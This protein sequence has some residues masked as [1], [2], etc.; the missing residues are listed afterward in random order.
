MSDVQ[1]F[2]DSLPRNE[3][4]FVEWMEGMLGDYIARGQAVITRGPNSLSVSWPVRGNFET[5]SRID[6]Y[7]IGLDGAPTP[8]AKDSQEGE[9]G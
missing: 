3:Q 8:T 4:E 7:G 1:D 6:L 9:E 2:I 5:G